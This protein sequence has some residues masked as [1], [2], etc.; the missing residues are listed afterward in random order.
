MGVSAA[1][2]GRLCSQGAHSQSGNP[3][4]LESATQEGQA[5]R[6]GARQ[7]KGG[8]CLRRSLEEGGNNE[9]ATPSLNTFLPHGVGGS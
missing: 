7:S 3:R 2:Q 9:C 6:A 1:L 5:H 8:V 4:S